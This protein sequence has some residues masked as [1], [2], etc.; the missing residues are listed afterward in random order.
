M[1]EYKL[2]PARL[3]INFMLRCVLSIHL[4]M[5]AMLVAAGFYPLRLAHVELQQMAQA[6]AEEFSFVVPG[7]YRLSGSAVMLLTGVAKNLA[8]SAEETPAFVAYIERMAAL[9]SAQA[10]VK[11]KK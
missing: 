6:A 5:G 10:I 3:T 4:V 2:V 1:V 11:K 8:A 7:D 9:E